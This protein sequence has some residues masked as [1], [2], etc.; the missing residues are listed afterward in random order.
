M[1]PEGTPLTNLHVT[2]LEVG[3]PGREARRQ[4]GE[5]QGTVRNRIICLRQ[6][7]GRM[8]KGEN[9]TKRTLVAICAIFVA[10]FGISIDVEAQV[11][12]TISGFVRD[13]AGRHSG[14]R[15]QR[16]D[17]WSA[18]DPFGCDRRNGIFQSSRDAERKLRHYCAADRLFHTADDG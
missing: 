1:Y 10:V 14:R 7:Y 16:D 6:G 13:E 12:G 8:R 2:L 15:R 11:A 4:H 17:D 5:I 18:V 9:V 3:V